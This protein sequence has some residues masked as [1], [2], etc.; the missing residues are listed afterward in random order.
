MLAR[1]N[2]FFFV[3]SFDR[4]RVSHGMCC[5][6]RCAQEHSTLLYTL[7]ITMTNVEYATSLFFTFVF[8]FLFLLFRYL[9][10]L[11]G[12][13][14]PRPCVHLNFVYFLV[15]FVVPTSTLSLFFF[16]F[17]LSLVDH[18]S[19]R[20]CQC[21]CV[22][23]EHLSAALCSRSSGM[24]RRKRRRKCPEYVHLLHVCNHK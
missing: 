22:F 4:R 2:G 19:V 9:L 1:T 17:A 20:G 13:N 6:V 24:C 3:H 5:G 16:I 11:V 23:A 12:R 10:Y 8:N 15:I 18:F 7:Q 21:E 14:S